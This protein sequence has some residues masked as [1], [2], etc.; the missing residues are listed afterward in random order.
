[1]KAIVC[2]QYGTAGNLRLAEVEKPA[3]KDGQVLVRVAAASLN[4]WDADILRGKPLL[5]RLISGWFKPR[6]PILGAD[7]AGTV[8]AVGKNVNDFRP[9]DE[10][11]GDIAESGFGG[12]AEYVAVPQKLL[13]RKPP[14]LTFEQA[15]ALPQAG[16]LAL[17]GLRYGGAARAVRKGQH[18]LINGACGGVGTLALQY[19]K[20]VGAEVTCVDRASKFGL[21]RSLGADHLFDYTTADYTRN[22]IQYDR[23]LDVQAFRSVADYRRA[24]RPGGTFAMIGGS[25]G[26]LL[27]QLM[28]FSPLLSVFGTRTIGLM[29]YKPNRDDLNLIT[30]L[31]QE[32]TVRPVIDKVYSLEET[33]EAFRYF[34]KGMVKGKIVIQIA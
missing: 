13:A 14:S 28:I 9:G 20:S 4:S 12:F 22:G 15:A 21:L 8:E 26:W 10:V 25:M 18:V 30:R 29:G 2:T 24:L 31:F 7:I 34:G 27:L 17:Q 33:A 23:I 11:F 1:V 3:P 16:L 6:H 32:G 5:V 19:L